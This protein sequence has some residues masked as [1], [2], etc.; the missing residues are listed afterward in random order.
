MKKIIFFAVMFPMM[1]SSCSSEDEDPNDK[2]EKLLANTSWLYHSEDN[3]HIL[4]EYEDYEN[5][6]QLKSILQICPSLKYTVGEHQITEN[7]ETIDLCKKEGHSNHIDALLEF[8]TNDCTYKEK[9]YR[10]IQITNSSIGNCDYKFKEGT[11]IGTLYGTT[12]VAITVKS[13]GI[14]QASTS[15]DILVLPL[16]G[17]YTYSLNIRRYTS[18]E[19]K[20][21][22]TDNSFTTSYQVSGNEITFSS[23]D[24]IWNGIL[25]LS[26][27]SMKF[28]SKKPVD[29][30][31][32]VFS[33]K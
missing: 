28:S 27:T 14:Y 22:L 12:H 16:D 3:E 9:A 15:G 11:Y 24:N 18:I 29:K 31:L 5:E 25:D 19:K 26:K 21:T 4:K 23:S 6:H 20:E 17:N 8:N 7:E 10:H 13:Y 30:E 32:Y 1:F 2:T 33:I